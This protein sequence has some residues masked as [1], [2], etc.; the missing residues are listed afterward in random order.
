MVN[1]TVQ[2]LRAFNGKS[3][4]NM[5]AVM[6][7]GRVAAT[8]GLVVAA[9]ALGL[10]TPV[11]AS[12]KGGLAAAQEVDILY[13]GKGLSPYR[14]TSEG[15]GTASEILQQ[16]HGLAEQQDLVWPSSSSSSSVRTFADGLMAFA[17]Q[18]RSHKCGERGFVG[19][20]ME[21]GYQVTHFTRGMLLVVLESGMAPGIVDHLTVRDL[22]R[23]TPD[24]QKHMSPIMDWPA[25]AVLKTF[26]VHAL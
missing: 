20:Q 21:A 25:H 9:K 7:V 22:S 19:G 23:W 11:V 12:K 4:A 8:T 16:L 3:L 1:M 18:A 15:A 13:L 5:H 14:L 10:I 24:Q 2:I 17:R 26:G 6:T